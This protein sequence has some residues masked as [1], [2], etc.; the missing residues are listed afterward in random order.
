[1]KKLIV[2]LV[3]AA[4]VAGGW[5]WWSSTKNSK[6]PEYKTTV[7]EKGEIVE[8]VSA[9][10][11]INPVSTVQVGSQVSGTI[12]EIFVDFNDKVTAGQVIAKIDPRLLE[13]SVIQSRGNLASARASLERSQ[14]QQAEAE[15][16]LKRLESL[17]TNGFVAASEVDTARANFDGA[18]AQTKSAAAQVSQAEGSLTVA[19]TNLRFTTILSPVDGIVISRAVDVGQT[20]AASFQTPTLFSIAKD[21]TRMQVEASIDEADIGRVKVGLP[22]GFTVD[23][24]PGKKFRGV[25]VQVRNAPIVTQNVVTY[26]TVIRVDNKERLLRPGMTANVVVEISRRDGVLKI[27]NAALRYKPT[28]AQNSAASA[29]GERPREKGKGGADG[30]RKIYRLG[31]DKKAEPVEVATG[32]TDGVFT[33][34]VEGQLAAGDNVVVEEG[35]KNGKSAKSTSPGGMGMGFGPP[36]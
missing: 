5:F 33:E 23:A 12:Q 35:S 22:V 10:G 32:A 9:T 28:A 7:V 21:L 25:V 17:F 20:V 11:T 30:K 19:E 26:V 2:I 1:M 16:T 36:R 13:A 24:W 3:L 15:R 14:V 27:A 18:T 8:S 34:I 6:P 29:G 4:A 31:P